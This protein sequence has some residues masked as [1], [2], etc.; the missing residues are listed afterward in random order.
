MKKQELINTIYTEE[1][2]RR[3]NEN[4]ITTIPVAESVFEILESSSSVVETVF[5]IIEP[6]QKYSKLIL[7]MINRFCPDI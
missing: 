3:N 6:V 1:I 2:N 4:V 5:E 7:H